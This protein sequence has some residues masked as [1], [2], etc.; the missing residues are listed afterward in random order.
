M[1]TVPKRDAPSW[2]CESCKKPQW[3][4]QRIYAVSLC[5]LCS[6]FNRLFH[7]ANDRIGYGLIRLAAVLAHPCQQCA[8]DPGAWHTRS[9][10]CP[11]REKGE[12]L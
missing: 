4:P 12:E 10:F 7:G 2:Y 3:Q 9:A 8:E 11:H 1:K 6:G 5:F